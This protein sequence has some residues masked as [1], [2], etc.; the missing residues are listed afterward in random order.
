MADGYIRISDCEALPGMGTMGDHSLNSALASDLA[1]D[2]TKPVVLLFASLGAA[3]GRW[4]SR[5]SSLTRASRTRS[6][7]VERSTG[8]WQAMRGM[9]EHYDLHTWLWQANPTDVFAPWNPNM[10]CE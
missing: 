3:Q 7:L 10:S 9:P 6:P 5:S 2:P 8:R 1:L 4:A